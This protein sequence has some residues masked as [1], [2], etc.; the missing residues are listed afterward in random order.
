[1][2][3]ITYFLLSALSFSPMELLA[4]PITL[5]TFDE[6][7]G[8]NLNW[9]VRTAAPDQIFINLPMVSGKNKTLY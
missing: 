8:L 5:L 3:I 2:R 9:I 6:T 7:Y 1:M 4:M